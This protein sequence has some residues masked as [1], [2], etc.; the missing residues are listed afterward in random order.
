[1]PFWLRPFVRR[2]LAAITLGNHV[3]FR[4]G[5]R[6]GVRLVAH[7]LVH[8][9]QQQA[10]GRVRHAW[11][12]VTEYFRLRRS[13]LDETA[14]YRAISYEVEA[15]ARAEEVLTALGGVDTELGAW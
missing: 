1:M 7:E 5:A 3:Y 10:V 14:A 6:V 12:Y 2:Q 9:A 4:P 13:G 8:V 11:R 15:R